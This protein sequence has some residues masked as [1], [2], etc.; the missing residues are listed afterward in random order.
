M[1]LN[2]G[3]LF[4]ISHTPPPEGPFTFKVKP[5]ES[6]GNLLINDKNAYRIG[7]GSKYY[8]LEPTARYTLLT[9]ENNPASF[10]AIGN[11]TMVKADISAGKKLMALE[12]D[13][14]KLQQLINIAQTKESSSANY[15]TAAIA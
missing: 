3:A 9:F 6:I 11:P 2:L 7:D 4:R 5:G 12:G 8:G 15:N 10:I 1:S 13:L 14:F